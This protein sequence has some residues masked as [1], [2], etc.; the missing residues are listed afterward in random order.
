MTSDCLNETLDRSYIARREH[1]E[2]EVVAGAQFTA[3]DVAMCSSED[4]RTFLAPRDA[5][6][7]RA[8]PLALVRSRTQLSLHIAVAQ[9]SE[10]VRSKL[11]FLCGLEVALTIVPAEVLEQAIPKAYYGS[12]L[13]LRRYI[14][15]IAAVPL[16]AKDGV[17]AID[18]ASSGPSRDTSQFAAPE[19]KGD[20]AQFL[21]AILEFAAVRG[22]SDLHLSPGADSVVVK[23]RIDGELCSLEGNPYAKS[24][25][26]QVISRLKVLAALDVTNRRLPQDGAFRFMVG[27]TV[28]SAR[29]STLPSVHGESA[30]IRLLDGHSIPEIGSLG[31]E[32]TTLLVV[33]AALDRTEGLILLTGPTGS[34]K[35]TTMYSVVRELA[36]RGHHV[37]TVED[38]VE[39]PLPGTVQVQVC[40]EQGLD[41]PRAIRSVLRHDPDVLLIGEMRDGVSASMALDAAST[42]HLTVSS[43][44][45]GSSLQAIGRLEVLGVPRSR[46][47]PAVAIVVNQQLLPKLCQ[48]CKVRDDGA[49]GS[50][51]LKLG[52][53]GG[54]FRAVGC[55][56][57]GGTGYLGRVLVTE[58]L[59]I[60]SQRAKDACYRTTTTAELLEAL[61]AGACIPWSDSLQHH[62]VRGDIS[63]AQLERF[64]QAEVV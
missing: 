53:V 20:A 33:R 25:H 43:L 3:H 15:R 39:N 8:L 48:A 11:R 54:L 42:G 19:A 36:R 51:A 4:A 46:S 21:T 64:V 45:V 18:G 26:E 30:V 1:R 16:H 17:H 34:G 47:V 59:D 32:P 23:M 31:F 37:V 60:Q 13:R 12:E 57:C 44:H 61:P 50:V 6:A 22:A 14:D 9:D 49:A 24:F 38:P 7:L 58:L 27:S 2:H 5:L 52:A 55:V 40:T 41:Y 35:T 56:T 28:R 63:L 29:V 10:Q 62:L